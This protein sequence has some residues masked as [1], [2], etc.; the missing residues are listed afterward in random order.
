MQGAGQPAEKDEGLVGEE[1][2]TEDDE[3]RSGDVAVELDAERVN[4]PGVP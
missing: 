4:D 1:L 3:L 2:R